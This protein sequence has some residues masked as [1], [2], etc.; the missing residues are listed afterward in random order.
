MKTNFLFLIA[1]IHFASNAQQVPT[2]NSPGGIGPSG[3]DNAQFWSRAGNLS[4]Q[5]TATNNI[6]G[7]R[8]NSGIYTI[9]DNQNRMK[10]NGSVNYPVNGFAG[11]RDGYLLLGYSQNYA[12]S[13]FTG[14][15]SGAYSQ[16][17]LNGPNGSFVQNG[18]YRPWMQTGVTFTDNDDLSYFGLR[19]VGTGTDKTETILSWSDNSSAP[20]GPDDLVLRFTAAGSNSA[21]DAADL[22]TP[23]DVD[24][25]HVARFTGEGDFGLGNTFGIDNPIYVE[26]QS[27]AHYSLSNLQSVWQQYTNR[28]IAVGTGTSETANDGLRIGIL[29][30]NDANANGTAAIYNQELKPILL[31]TNANSNAIN[32]VSGATGE[33]VRI[34]SVNTPTNLPTG[35]MGIY[36]PG[37]SSTNFTRMSVS[38]NPSTPVTRPLSL[39]HLGYNST[40]TST[41]TDGWR[42]WMDVGMFVSNKSDNVYLGLKNETTSILVDRQDAVLGW[43]DNP[44]TAGGNGPDNLRFIFTSASTSVQ[45]PASNA[46]TVNGLEVARMEPTAASTLSGNYGMMGIGDFSPAG[47]NTANPVDAKLDIDGDLRVRTVTQQDSLLRVLV[48]DSADLNRVHYRNI[49][50]NLGTGQGFVPCSDFTPAAFLPSDSKINLNNHNVYFE[51]NDS[52]GQN[53][54]SVGYKCSSILPGKFSSLQTHPTSINANSTAIHASNID[55]S[56]ANALTFQGVYGESVGPNTGENY[57]TKTTQIGGDFFAKN[58]VQSYGVRGISGSNP[59]NSVGSTNVG[60]YFH[61]RSN[62]PFNTLGIGVVGI[63]TNAGTNYGV[64][65]AAPDISPSTLG[66]NFAGYFNGDLLY[67]GQFG[68]SDQ[69]FKTN[70][71]SIPNALNIVNNLIP[72]KYEYNVSAF[73]GKMNFKQGQQYGFIAQEVQT[74]LPELVGTAINPAII[75][76][77]GNEI[78]QAFQFKTL[79]YMAIIPILTKAIQEQNAIISHQDSMINELNNRLSNLENCI[80]SL[81]LCNQNQPTQMAQPT[82]GQTISLNTVQSIVL[83]QN[84]PNPFAEQTVISYSIPE[85]V[86]KADI[87]FY[88]SNGKLINSIFIKERGN[89]QL[90]VFAN[91]LST[92]I[93]TYTLVADGQIVASKKMV[94][95]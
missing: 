12:T 41:T 58:G 24:G 82:T 38:H 79:N 62:L 18:G 91:D 7:T 89:S 52:L 75:D 43:G 44:T 60:G 88:D 95:Q 72:R 22:A 42:P 92:G 21:I 14:A 81:N 68:T 78:S 80:N 49:P 28:N 83:N 23:F 1:I 30:N 73:Q 67:T 13:L 45:T 48:I 15:T 40:T 2:V 85:S 61:S 76:S 8:W 36:T 94:K 77:S 33:R 56:N 71:D 53:H 27:L 86:K 6:F 74:V 3:Q 25:L 66:P 65:G 47:P 51:N 64:Y 57:N 90:N 34:T 35:G 93:Y 84:V 10:L 31:S 11:Q 29:G 39:L 55:V 4:A 5:G 26:P 63:S 32:P 20:S 37:G 87:L 19:K 50:L 59:N 70:I 46:N 16:L 69:M 54:V 17:H 9:T